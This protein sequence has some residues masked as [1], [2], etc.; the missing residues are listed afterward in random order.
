M[1]GLVALSGTSN[2]FT[3]D[4]TVPA[5][6]DDGFDFRDDQIITLWARIVNSEGFYGYREI[7]L[8]LAIPA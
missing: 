1:D 3:F 7:I 2:T 6:D 4:Y 5:Q 8:V